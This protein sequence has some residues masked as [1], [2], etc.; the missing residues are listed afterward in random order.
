MRDQVDHNPEGYKDLRMK[1]LTPENVADVLSTS[2][3]TARRL[4]LDGIIPSITIRCGRRK[5]MLRVRSEA[6]EKW[7]MAKE[8][9]QAATKNQGG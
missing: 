5:K 6:L 3:S 4:L 1:L 9:E 8:R 2:R 7:V